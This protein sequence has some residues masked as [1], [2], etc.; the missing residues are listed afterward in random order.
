MVTVTAVDKLIC[1]NVPGCDI[2][3]FWTA[4]LAIS[5]KEKPANNI[6]LNLPLHDREHVC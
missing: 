2:R 3:I 5:F 6:L 1:D 4:L